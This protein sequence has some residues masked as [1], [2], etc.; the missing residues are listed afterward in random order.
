MK[1]LTGQ[2]K[3]SREQARNAAEQQMWLRGFICEVEDQVEKMRRHEGEAK[4]LRETQKNE[5]L[6]NAKRLSVQRR[7]ADIRSRDRHVLAVQRE[8]RRERVATENA[9]LVEA[10][11]A[12][13]ANQSAARLSQCLSS[14]NAWLD[15]QNSNTELLK[16]FK[17]LER[18]FH[19]APSADT[20]S[21][22]QML[23]SPAGICLSAVDAKISH[24]GLVPDD[25]FDRLQGCSNG[26][27]VVYTDFMQTVN[28]LG[29][30]LDTSLVRNLFVEIESSAIDKGI[31]LSGL[32]SRL[33]ETYR[34]NGIAGS[35][36]K[37]YIS[38]A[39][40]MMMFH[41][42]HADHNRDK[43]ILEHQMNKKQ[44]RQIVCDNIRASRLLQE[45]IAIR[46]EKRADFEL[47]RANRAA[48]SV[49]FMYRRRKA[50]STV[51][52]LQWKLARKELQNDEQQR[53]K[54]AR[55][56]LDF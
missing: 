9:A 2:E 7:K 3:V 42:Y 48:K 43:K 30:A 24:L 8:K 39:H 38:P 29:M 40:Q 52:K 12:K 34:Y 19:M 53:E 6:A 25:F 37:K 20:E 33:E 10:W 45:R 47:L 14:T 46:N 56:Y 1:R 51:G 55:Y 50:Q 5:K 18:D 11:E 13:W 54:L 21:T 44:L 15:G 27:H 35:P 26:G 4:V 41:Y 28:S 16:L 36:W 22:E 17:E 23:S 32:K 49:Q 31:S